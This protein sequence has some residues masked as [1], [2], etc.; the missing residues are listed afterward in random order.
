MFGGGG[1]ATTMPSLRNLSYGAL[2]DATQTSGALL[3]LG[4]DSEERCVPQDMDVGRGWRKWLDRVLV[5]TL[6][7]GV[8]A[9]VATFAGSRT[10]ESKSQNKASFS[11]KFNVGVKYEEAQVRVGGAASMTPLGFSAFN[12]YNIRD[13]QPGQNYPWLKDNMKLIEPYR[14]TILMVTSPVEGLDYRWVLRVDGTDDVQASASGGKVAVILTQLENHMVTLK[15]VNPTGV[16]TRHLEETVMVK[17]VRRE[18]RTLTEVERGEL[19]DSVRSSIFFNRMISDLRRS[20]CTY[21]VLDARR[22]YLKKKLNAAAKPSKHSP[23]RGK[24]VKAFIRW[25]DSRLQRQNLFM[26]FSLVPRWG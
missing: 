18:I 12:F 4:R 25:E 23:G 24:I 7:I 16:V 20:R 11:T 2:K 17:Y 26:S 1:I 5:G 8:A 15:E 14:E 3:D 10:L 13:G 9:A 22:L 19:L 6:I 21:Y